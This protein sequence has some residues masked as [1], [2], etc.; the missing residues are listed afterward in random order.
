MGNESIIEKEMFK[1]L[2]EYDIDIKDES[3]N[4]EE[5]IDAKVN[6]RIS[7]D[8]MYAYLSIDSPKGGKMITKEDVD[9]ILKEQKIVYGIDHSMIN[10]MIEENIFVIEKVIAKGREVIDGID[11]KLEYLFDVN[12]KFQPKMDEDGKVDFKELNL[13]QCVQKGIILAKRTL[14]TEGVD[15]ITVTGKIIRA[16]NGKEIHFKKGKNVIETQDGLSLVAIQD[17]Q[18]KLV[19]DK[20]T[21]LQVYE[22]KGNV[23]NSTGNIYFNGKVAIKG[24]V[25]TGFKIEC[26]DDVEVYGVVE[27]ATIITEGNIILHKGI[28]GYNCGKLISKRDIVAKYMENCY[29]KADGN[30]S[31][32]AIMHCNLEAKGSVSA[33]GKKGLIVGGQIRANYEVNAKTIGSSMATNTKID[34]GIDPEIKEKYESLKQEL[35][36]LYKNKENVRKAIELLTRI[37]KNVPLPKEKQDLLSKS[38]HTE[39]YL[40]E[41]IET[42][43]YDLLRLQNVV[44]D[45]STGKVNVS[46]IIHPG[47]KITIGNSLY[48]IRD[49]IHSATIVREDGEIKINSYTE[50][51]S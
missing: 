35:E 51:R 20:I 37:S 22:V 15:G 24:N 26:T 9:H 39:G 7:K 43:N 19:D 10:R 29:V 17:G 6:I 13:I 47:V 50:S 38:I 12:T 18:V 33:I 36:L 41:K 49:D 30:I 14:P 45:L 25:R 8:E 42:V 23:D 46:S 40:N 1:Q 31:A 2:E 28:Q 11:G 4:E 16:K 3:I 48:Y 21:V 5:P 44:Q 32:E 27:G 34:V